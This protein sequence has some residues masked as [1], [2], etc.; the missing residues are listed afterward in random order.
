MKAHLLLII[1]S[2]SISAISQ[3]QIL[4]VE[5]ARIDSLSGEKTY[6][7]SLETKFNLYN[8]S[9][10][11]T[12]QA[13]F[14]N[15]SND[16]NAVYAPGKHSYI[17]LGSLSYTENNSNTILNNGYLHIRSTFNYRERWSQELFAQAQYDNFRGLTDRLLGGGAIGWQ[18]IDGGM[19]SLSIGS[20]PMYELEIWRRPADED[21]TD[22]GTI[23]KRLLKL[24]TYLKLRWD[25]NDRISFNTVAYYQVGYDDAIEAARNRLSANSNL[26]VQ[27]A[28]FLK[29]TTSLSLAYEDKPVIPITKFIYTLEN[30]LTLSF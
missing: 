24:S 5:K 1:L 10:G 30:G 11:A 15:L 18:A 29:F 26:N 4:N 19:F 20:G 13:E 22:R 16:L 17:G 23:E 14:I 28:S 12:E 8:R 3:A 2:F 6:R 21:G 25:I 27:L 9:A 7:I